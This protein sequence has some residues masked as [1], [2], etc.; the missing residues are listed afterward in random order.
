MYE[1]TGANLCGLHVYFCTTARCSYYSFV[2]VGHF[3]FIWSGQYWMELSIQSCSVNV[4]FVYGICAVV[5]NACVLFSKTF[6]GCYDFFETGEKCLNHRTHY[7]FLVR[8][9]QEVGGKV[10]N[11]VGLYK[12]DC[13]CLFKKQCPALCNLYFLWTIPIISQDN[14]SMAKIRKMHKPSPPHKSS[15]LW[16]SAFYWETGLLSSLYFHLYNSFFPFFFGL[17]VSRGQNGTK[18]SIR[19][20]TFLRSKN[21]CFAPPNHFH[22][23]PKKVRVCS[24][25]QHCAFRKLS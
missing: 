19:D 22:T 15:C 9:M 6:Y 17:F 24:K 8:E 23:V 11:T 3:L 20:G 1:L 4:A 21:V 2:H 5:W 12:N 7:T 10:V 18:K 13:G 16:G 14:M 25:L